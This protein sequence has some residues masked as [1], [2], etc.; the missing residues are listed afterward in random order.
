MVI[1]GRTKRI[2]KREKVA[3]ATM[4]GHN[5]KALAT[6]NDLGLPHDSPVITY[7]SENECVSAKVAP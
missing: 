5:I 2:G 1:D 7:P 3:I 4:A 6:A